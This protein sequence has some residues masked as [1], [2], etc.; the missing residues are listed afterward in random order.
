MGVFGAAWA[1]T[2]LYGYFDMILPGDQSIRLVLTVVWA[3]TLATF[4]WW[5]PFITPAWYKEW[6]K[7]SGGKS[8]D[9][10]H[11]WPLAEWHEIEK[12]ERAKRQAKARKRI[13]KRQENAGR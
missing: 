5:P 3:G 12:H 4:L 6:L 8:L 7:R 11:L 13:Q 2:V 1:V 10:K 9:P